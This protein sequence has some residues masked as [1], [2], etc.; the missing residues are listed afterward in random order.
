MSSDADRCAK[1]YLPVRR[2]QEGLQCDGFF[3]TWQH[4]TCKTSIL[5]REYR[6]AI[7]EG[8][9][10][11]WRCKYCTNAIDSAISTNEAFTSL[12][13]PVAMSTMI[14]E[15]SVT[16]WLSASCLI[17]SELTYSKCIKGSTYYLGDKQGFDV[18][19]VL[20]FFVSFKS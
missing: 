19:S 4:R 9:D 14:D 10:I 18:L 16:G 12:A 7:K 17:S 20:L 1:C 8:R 5:Q 11:D 15:A 13:M 6:E 2:R 3:F